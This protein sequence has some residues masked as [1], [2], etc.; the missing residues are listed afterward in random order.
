VRARLREDQ[1]GRLEQYRVPDE[2]ARS[3]RT[4]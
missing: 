4:T 3:T 1:A 2:G